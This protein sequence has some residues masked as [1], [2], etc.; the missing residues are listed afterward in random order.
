MVRRR[1]GGDIP[2]SGAGGGAARREAVLDLN[3][4]SRGSF[5][6]YEVDFQAFLTHAHREALWCRATFVCR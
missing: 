5:A 4:Q 3:L 2:G 1:L 6:E